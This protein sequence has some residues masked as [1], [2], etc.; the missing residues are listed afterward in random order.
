M[1]I[2]KEYAGHVL[3]GTPLESPARG[4]RGMLQLPQLWKTPELKEVFVEPTRIDQ[5]MD[6][7]IRDPMNCIDVGCHLG[8]MINRIKRLSPHGK[9]IAIEPLPHKANWLKRK[10]PD[11]EVHQMALGDTTGEVE[12]YYQPT[13][14]AYSGLRLNGSGDEKFELL[15]VKCMPLDDLV[16]SDRQIG[17]I[18][19]TVEGAELSVL[20]GSQKMLERSHPTILLDC[21]SKELEVFGVVPKDIYNFLVHEQNYS[22]FLLKDFLNNGNPLSYESFFQAMQYPFQAFRF[23]AVYKSM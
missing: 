14:S 9:H 12:F 17:Y 16:P 18:K 15:R 4:L 10:Y 11:I 22:I 5:V 20:R 23:V 7:V 19:I 13:R 21:I 6:R 3:I 1:S 8:A 2:V